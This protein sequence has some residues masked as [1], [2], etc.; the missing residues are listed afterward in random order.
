MKITEIKNLNFKPVAITIKRD[1]DGFK[2]LMDLGADVQ[3]TLETRRGETKNFRSIATLFHDLG[4]FRSLKN[5]PIFLE[6]FE[7]TK[8]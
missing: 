1:D 4:E 2:L 8:N 7:N 3:E 6:D 5:V